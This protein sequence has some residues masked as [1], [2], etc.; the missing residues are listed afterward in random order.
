VQSVLCGAASNPNSGL[1]ENSKGAYRK[2]PESIGLINRE[3]P[4]V[5]LGA[6]GQYLK[7]TDPGFSPK[8]FGHN[9][10]SDMVRA[11]PELAVT[12]ENGSGYWVSLK[13]KPEVPP[14]SH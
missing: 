13:P 6:L 5:G 8:A 12:V 4:V 1:E 3:V 10:L 11:Y 7:R 9:A 2:R 14:T